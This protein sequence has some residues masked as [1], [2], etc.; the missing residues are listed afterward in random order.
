MLLVLDNALGSTSK[1]RLPQAQRTRDESDDPAPA[2]LEAMNPLLGE[3][4]A[5]QTRLLET[6]W[7][8]YLNRDAWPIFH[9][10]DLSLFLEEERLE[11]IDV[12]H[13]CPRIQARGRLGGYRWLWWARSPNDPADDDQIG[14]TVLGLSRIPSAS[15]EVALFLRG[16]KGLVN[17]LRALTP[18]PS[19]VQRA[20]VKQEAV[21]TGL[22]LP[23]G[24]VRHLGEIFEHEPS[25]QRFY[26]KPDP[27]GDWTMTVDLRRRPYAD[28]ENVRAYA[29]RLLYELA[30]P[31]PEPPPL[32]VSSLALPEAIDYLNVVW[33]EHANQ[34]LIVIRRAESAARLAIDCANADEFDSRVSALCG[35]LDQ[36]TIP[37]SATHVKLSGVRDLS[38]SPTAARR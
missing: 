30:P 36:L 29:D 14:L 20:E 6:I 21:Q 38:Q 35:I 2:V 9:F 23:S 19:K 8:S 11:A 18:S 16:L 22:R 37:E 1:S 31:Q 5:A 26:T 24:P 17:E 27:A 25:T 28:I 7:L 33:R 15:H 3:P 34:P 32:F 12:L 4:T 13:S 10:V